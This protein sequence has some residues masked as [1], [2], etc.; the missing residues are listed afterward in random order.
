MNCWDTSA[1]MKR[2]RLDDLFDLDS[3]D[4]FEEPKR[5]KIDPEPH[6]PVIQLQFYY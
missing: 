6:L 2:H 1:V 4:E 5:K 3:D